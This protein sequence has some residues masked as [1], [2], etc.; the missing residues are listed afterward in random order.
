ML[1]LGV[2]AGERNSLTVEVVV[3]VVRVVVVVSSSGGVV[4]DVVVVSVV[5]GHIGV[6][7]TI[8]VEVLPGT[9]MV[10]CRVNSALW[11]CV[12]LCNRPL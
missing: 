8:A 6:S 7:V 4:V 1:A 9:S 5:V 3:V 10:V 11:L 12:H 2:E